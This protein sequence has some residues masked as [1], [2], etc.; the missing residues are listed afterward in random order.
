[1]HN[2]SALKFPKSTNV[3]TESSVAKER[4]LLENGASPRVSEYESV[5]RVLCDHA[6]GGK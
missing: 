1:M 4:S 6:L 3:T 2:L 5:N